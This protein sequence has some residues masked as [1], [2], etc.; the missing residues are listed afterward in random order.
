MHGT[1][2]NQIGRFILGSYWRRSDFVVSCLIV[3]IPFLLLIAAGAY[4]IFTEGYGLLFSTLSFAC[5][6]ALLAFKFFLR[7][8]RSISI[9]EEVEIPGANLRQNWTPFEREVYEKCSI[10]IKDKTRVL[11]DWDEGLFRI[12][13]DVATEVAGSMSNGKK[14]S[15]DV[16]VPEILGLLDQ[17]GR[18]CREFIQDTT[19][20]AFLHRVSV[21]NILWVLRNRHLLARSAEG[22]S[23]LLKLVGLVVNPPAG[24][25]RIFESL[26]ADN[27][28]KYLS[29]QFQIE[30][31]RGVLRY[32]AAKSIELY[33]G[34]LRM[35]SLVAPSLVAAEPIKI[36]IV[37]QT[38][39]GKSSLIGA[40]AS[41]TSSPNSGNRTNSRKRER[42][43]L[44]G[45]QCTFVEAP[46]LENPILNQWR[47]P[48]FGKRRS[49][50]R[51]PKQIEANSDQMFLDCDMVVWVA[52]ADQPARKADVD[53]LEQFHA[54]FGIQKL[55]IVPPLLVAV[56]HVDRRPIISA[57]PDGD[58]LSPAQILKIKDALRAAARPFEGHVAIP[59][60]LSPPVWNLGEL[61]EAIR[62][63][64]PDACGAQNNRIRSNGE[65]KPTGTPPSNKEY[66]SR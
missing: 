33:S 24:A 26:I 18:E 23:Y 63:A 61:I 9:A 19:M 64:M 49:R 62:T 47:L 5:V 55:R 52:R 32:V 12:A 37:G 35:D 54:A 21:N 40:L 58:S 1:H 15:L 44:D 8:W 6:L 14:D 53:Y 3:G 65:K 41:A 39:S 25:I 10:R 17:V 51:S 48:L 4:F 28:V 56:T 13:H 31:Q 30:L 43:V 60:K 29:D 27:N 34:R 7:R 59:V 11:L 46:G 42:I 22:G 20:F 50:I 38:G 16:S 2:T 66:S 45:I 36:L 57:W